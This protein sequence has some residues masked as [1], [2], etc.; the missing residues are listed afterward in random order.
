MESILETIKK[1]KKLYRMTMLFISLLISALVYNIFLLPLNIVSGGTGGIAT[2]TKYVYHIDPSLMI[3]ILSVACILI[4][5]M[6]LG[7]E[8]TSGAILSTF[9]YPLLVSLT[10]PIAKL[11]PIET[12]DTFI[13][14]IFAGVLSGLSSGIMYKTGYNS[15]GFTV[16][17]QILYEKFNVAIS[18]SSII[19]NGLVVLLGGVFFGSANAMYA[20]IL[21]Y[22]SNIVMDKVLL[23]ISNNKAFYIITSDEENIK[24]YII[25][26][27]HH[28]V[29]SFDVKGG[30]LEKKRKVLL[31]VIPSREYYKVTD[32]IKTID[33]DAFFVVTDSY[34]VIGGK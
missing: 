3:L 6:Y 2:V 22:I 24:K 10:A 31:S 23:G 15:G 32:G 33:K 25:E 8:K 28:N 29:T 5:I 21:L 14:I 34:E 12:N 18:K 26:K 13:I 16:I 1:Q 17:C 9:I 7:V 11:F 19:I 30:F 4:S 20:I 27:L